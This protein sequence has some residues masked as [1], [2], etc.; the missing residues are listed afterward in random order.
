VQ[1]T[2]V[3]AAGVAQFHAAVPGCRIQHDG[4]VIEPR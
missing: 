4:G 1:N 2:G 3:T